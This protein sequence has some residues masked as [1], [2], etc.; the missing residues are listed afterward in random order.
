M[1]QFMDTKQQPLLLAT[2]RLY[3]SHKNTVPGSTANPMRYHQMKVSYPEND[4]APMLMYMPQLVVH[5]I[6]KDSP[7]MPTQ[8]YMDNNAD[9]ILRR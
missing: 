5:E 1:C 6:D 8:N 4:C 3:S 9:T 7:L 2:L